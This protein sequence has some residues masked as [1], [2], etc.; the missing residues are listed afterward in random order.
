MCLL[1]R[2]VDYDLLSFS[3]L[4]FCKLLTT[5]LSCHVF[6]FIFCHDLVN[7]V[8][9]AFW[10][11]LVE[12][13]QYI[14]VCFGKNRVLRN[15]KQAFQRPSCLFKTTINTRLCIAIL[16]LPPILRLRVLE[17][18]WNLKYFPSFTKFPQNWKL[19]SRYKFWAISSSS[20]VRLNEIFIATV[21]D[22]CYNFYMIEYDEC[23]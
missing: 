8:V 13:T 18:C 21:H 6:I 17:Y 15:N 4:S 9:K 2:L 11:R 20:D 5:L 23:Q 7:R 19:S 10:P 16:C 12:L 1:E 22:E 14:F 3:A